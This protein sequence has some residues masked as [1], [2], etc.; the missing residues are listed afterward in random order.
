MLGKPFTLV[1]EGIPAS[2]LQG[3]L[4]QSHYFDYPAELRLNFLKNTSEEAH[5]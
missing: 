2:L 3:W 4:I 1:G 5:L